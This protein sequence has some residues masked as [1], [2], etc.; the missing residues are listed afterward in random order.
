MSQA[1]ST[2]AEWLARGVEISRA[3]GFPFGERNAGALSA[4]AVEHLLEG[5]DLLHSAPGRGGARKAALLSRRGPVAELVGS[6]RVSLADDVCLHRNPD[7]GYCGKDLLEAS[8]VEQNLN[9]C[10]EHMVEH[11]LIRIGCERQL[12]NLDSVGEPEVGSVCLVCREVSGETL[13]C[14]VCGG[15]LHAQCIA[16]HFAGVEVSE[17]N[18]CAFVCHACVILRLNEVYLAAA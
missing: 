10:A 7:L 11:V 6:I 2:L 3:E 12:G 18:P 8:A 16:D 1:T 14:E 17:V 13:A 15:A 4:V 9:L 5:A